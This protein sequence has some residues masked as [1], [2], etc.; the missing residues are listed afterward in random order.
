MLKRVYFCI[1]LQFRDISIWSWFWATLWKD[2]ACA[3]IKVDVVLSAQPYKTKLKTDHN[4]F[5]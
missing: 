3:L 4:L 1:W 2:I 5:T